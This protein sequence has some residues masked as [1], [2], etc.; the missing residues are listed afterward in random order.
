MKK[1]LWTKTALGTRG[2]RP[3]TEW[4]LTKLLKEHQQKGLDRV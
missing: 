4:V 3:T 2:D 1:A